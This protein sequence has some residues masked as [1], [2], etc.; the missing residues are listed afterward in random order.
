M[1]RYLIS[2]IIGQAAV[3]N[4]LKELKESQELS[5]SEIEKILIFNGVNEPS[6]TL[7]NLIKL[8]ILLPAGDKIV[9]TNHGH[10]LWLLINAANDGDIRS[11]FRKL[12]LLDPN[13]TPYEL[14]KEG[15]TL[16]FIHNLL[17]YPDFKRLFI[18]SPWINLR[19]KTLRKLQQALYTAQGNSATKID[20]LVI[21]K[22]INKRDIHFQTFLDNF[23]ALTKLGAE[24]VINEKLHSKLYIRDQGPSGGFT[25]AIFGSENLTGANN[26]ELGIKINNDL[27]IINKLIEYFFSLYSNCK[28]I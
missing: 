25:Q 15:M 27:S 6:D 14:V 19:K 12:T 3:F 26:I 24:I 22:P 28:P 8:G 9:I 4:F 20:F 17:T 5:L 10:K 18:C 11:C 23:D 16:E 7:E 1:Q 2:D 13:L 21:A